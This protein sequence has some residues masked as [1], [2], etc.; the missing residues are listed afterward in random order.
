MT[1]FAL[2]SVL[3]SRVFARATG[4]AVRRLPRATGVGLAALVLV[5]LVLPAVPASATTI[6][7]V[8]SPKG[9]EAWLVH[10][11]AIPLV[12]MQFAFRGGSSQDPAALP[13]LATMTVS[14]LD[15]GAGDLPASA[16]QKKLEEKAIEFS[17]QARRD[18]VVG[19]LRT[20]SENR[21]EAVR[22]VKL[23][24][25]APRFDTEAVE[26]IRA[27]ILAALS[28]ED[29]TAH[30]LAARAWWAAAYPNHPYGH[31][32]R[33]TP[34]AVK[35]ISADDL[36]GYV[37]RVL[38][39]DTLK[40]GIVGDIDAE[41][42]GKMIDEVFGSLPEKADLLPVPDVPPNNLG[43]RVTAEIDVPQSTVVLGGP[44][45]ARADPDFIPGYLV[46]HILGG[47][48][49][50]SRLYEQVREKRGL[51]YS[52]Y[53]QLAPLKNTA[54][55]LVSTATRADRVDESLKVIR[56]QIAAMAET[57]PTPEELDQAKSFLKGSY[58]LS[59]DSSVKI[60]A[61]LVQI[62]L[63]DLGIDYID[64]RKDLIDAVTIDDAKRVAKRF[65][66]G[67]M[68]VAVAGRTEVAGASP[69]A[70]EPAAAP[71]RPTGTPPAGTP[72]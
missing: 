56:E 62:Q 3:A 1:A 8:K 4:G 57:G 43:E 50:S 47:G 32:K 70:A 20:L 28:R 72:P 9:I 55:F 15:E 46:N 38:A 13:G 2:V 69:D 51:A 67:D 27:D 17:V 35:T 10:E 34:D 66:S 30:V 53:S 26:R 71:P 33:G 12:A 61:Q 36:R 44:G 41:A 52:V 7:R 22:L 65:L 24:L 6:E 18:T 37:K 40:I 68:L 63:D 39:R 48:S 42:A 19:S 11:P 45:I 60:A 29:K 31:P 5:A 64:R 49:F 25:T 59:F 21:D 54:V 16:F 58:A 23:A 14:L